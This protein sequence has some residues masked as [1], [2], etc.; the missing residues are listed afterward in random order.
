MHA[1][2]KCSQDLMGLQ[3]VKKALNQQNYIPTYSPGYGK[4]KNLFWFRSPEGSAF[5]Y[6]Y[7]VH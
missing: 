5:V 7:S 3:S 2:G 4:F 6:T 1:I